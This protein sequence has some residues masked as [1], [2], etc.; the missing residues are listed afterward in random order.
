MHTL[1][2]GAIGIYSH[3]FINLIIAI[4]ID[5]LKGWVDAIIVNSSISHIRTIGD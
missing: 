4:G 2:D 3:I 1:V 5:H